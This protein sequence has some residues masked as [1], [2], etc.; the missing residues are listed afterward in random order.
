MF[1]RIL[2]LILSLILSGAAASEPML[3]PDPGQPDTVKLEGGPL[4]LGQS[5]PLSLTIVN[6][7]IVAAYTLGFVFDQPAEGGFA[8]FD[9]VVYVGRMADPTVL[10]YRVNRRWDTDPAPPDSVMLGAMMMLPN[11]LPAGNGQILEVY[12]TGTATGVMTVDSGF[13]PPSAPF[14]L[15]DITSNTFTPQ[16]VVSDVEVVEGSPPPV[17]SLPSEPPRVTAGSTVEFSV[18]ASSPVAFPVELELISLTGYDDETVLPDNDPTFGSSNPAEFSWMT[19][20]D[21]I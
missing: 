1:R 18:G 16:L 6:D 2:I 17:I 9:S 12:F 20:L 4:I 11:K 15:T 7:E 19:T 5:V 8:V 3:G 21:G 14:T 13:F 10:S